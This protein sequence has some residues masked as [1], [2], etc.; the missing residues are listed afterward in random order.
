MN[1]TIGRAFYAAGACTL[2]IGADLTVT[3]TGKDAYPY[4]AAKLY[5]ATYVRPEDDGLFKSVGDSVDGRIA[6]VKHSDPSVLIILETTPGDESSRVELWAR[7]EQLRG[8]IGE[9]FYATGARTLEIGADLTVTF[10]GW[11]GG[12]KEYEVEYA[13]PGEREEKERSW[14]EIAEK[15]NRIWGGAAPDEG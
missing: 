15:M 8:A 14:N 10:T 11:D 1:R 2:E 13:R 12:A 6:S 9:A 5:Q 3:F 7:S 4:H